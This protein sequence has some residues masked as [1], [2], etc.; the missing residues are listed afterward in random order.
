MTVDIRLIIALLTSIG[1]N[2]FGLW[3]VRDILGRLNWI[4]RNINDIVDLISVYRN[5]VKNIY[6]LENFYGDAEIRGLLEHTTVFLEEL[7]EYQQTVLVLEP[8]EYL[9]NNEE[10]QDAEKE[11]EVQK[12]VLYAGTRRRDS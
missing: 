3:Y 1:I 10:T 6:S 7:E 8:T 11:D 12:D 9:E 4:S 2:I 5:H